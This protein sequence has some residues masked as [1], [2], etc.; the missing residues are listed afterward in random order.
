[1]YIADQMFSLLP[2]Q[3]TSTVKFYIRLIDVEFISQCVRGGGGRLLY[4]EANMTMAQAAYQVNPKANLSDF[5]WKKLRSRP[6]F[7]MTP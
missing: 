7:L 5:Q 1:M 3:Y 4:V 2:Q 6:Q